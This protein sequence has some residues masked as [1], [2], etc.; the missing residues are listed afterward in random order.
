MTDDEIEKRLD[1]FMLLDDGPAEQLPALSELE[2][3]MALRMIVG[4]RT[5]LKASVF[6]FV[7]AIG[8]AAPVGALGYWL[9]GYLEYFFIP[10][11]VGLVIVG[12]V[13]Y[14]KR[15]FPYALLCAGAGL[16]HVTSMFFTDH[17]LRIA[18]GVGGATVGRA[19]L[20][21]GLDVFLL[22]AKFTLHNHAC[23]AVAI[24]FTTLMFFCCRPSIDEGDLRRE[25]A[26]TVKSA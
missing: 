17:M 26:R 20:H 13:A 19:L 15:T 16:L 18:K 12:T 21:H 3:E 10:P 24:L 22:S 4:R 8:F 11:M 2:R 23:M 25:L 1:G 14:H 9:D 6:L 5:L 7:A